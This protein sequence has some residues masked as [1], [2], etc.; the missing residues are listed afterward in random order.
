MST[1]ANTNRR[2]VQACSRFEGSIWRP[3][4]CRRCFANKSEHDAP[5]AQSGSQSS[6]GNDL[7]PSARKKASLTAT[8]SVG[9]TSQ[10]GHGNSHSASEAEPGKWRR[11]GSVIMTSGTRHVVRAEKKSS[12]GSGSRF[13]RAEVVVVGSNGTNGAQAPS[14]N[15][16]AIV[17]SAV[18]FV[19]KPSSAE[20]GEAAPSV[21]AK[22]P[23][24]SPL[25]SPCSPLD[26][27][28]VSSTALSDSSGQDGGISSLSSDSNQST[29]VKGS[30]EHKRFQECNGEETSPESGLRLEQA[31]Q[32][33]ERQHSTDQED[34][35]HPA[36]R[37]SIVSHSRM[38][39]EEMEGG[40]A[41]R[42]RRNSACNGVPVTPSNAFSRQNS[43][44]SMSTEALDQTREP[45]R[46]PSSQESAGSQES[47]TT[48][49]MSA[50][51]TSIDNLLSQLQ[52]PK[53]SST[54]TPAATAGVAAARPGQRFGNNHRYSP[55]H[56]YRLPRDNRRQG[57]NKTTSAGELT[58]GSSRSSRKDHQ[59]RRS[60]TDGPSNLLKP[61]KDLSM[62]DANM[63]SPQSLPAASLTSSECN[64]SDSCTSPTLPDA[65]S[66]QPSTDE[67]T[68]TIKTHDASVMKFIVSQLEHISASW[69][70][71]DRH[72]DDLRAMSLADYRLV[73][74]MA[75]DW[76]DGTAATPLWQ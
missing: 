39:S 58:N 75:A 28:P 23:P 7:T 9:L 49:S 17:T 1:R 30:D 14:S 76:C 32:P 5:G 51:G 36:R 19:A 22:S 16:V 25:D 71:S 34:V 61:K 2:K 3:L 46:R 41:A 10:E 29:L 12:P 27:R 15:P 42:S 13:A 70:E 8:R 50:L 4:V 72:V 60:M 64:G 18:Q 45:P 44:A 68:T 20:Q 47:D 52:N 62:S 37:S 6:P 40:G 56:Q 33:V 54:P 66:P 24:Q 55:H 57:F 65:Q 48:A 74:D 38:A 31:E 35:S 63:S 59:F 11:S 73:E 53:S 43:V 26:P 21:A 67:S 69:K